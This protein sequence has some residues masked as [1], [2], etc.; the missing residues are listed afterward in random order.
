[1]AFFC[2]AKVCI[3]KNTLDTYNT[4]NRGLKFLTEF[5]MNAEALC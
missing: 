1:M 5:K 4:Y 3:I 2:Y